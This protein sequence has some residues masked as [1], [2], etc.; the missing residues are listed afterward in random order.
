MATEWTD[1]GPVIKCPFCPVCGTPP[2]FIWP[3]LHQCW[4]PNEDCRVFMWVPWDTAAENLA[5]Q[6]EIKLPDFEQ[7]APTTDQTP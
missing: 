3:S 1:D 6:S 2:D 5:D 4:C 7:E